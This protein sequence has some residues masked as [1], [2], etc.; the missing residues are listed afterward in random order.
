MR[1]FRN[2]ALSLFA[3]IFLSHFW[4]Y[5]SIAQNSI[6]LSVYTM[7]QGG[8]NRSLAALT[9][10]EFQFSSVPA[11]GL[12]GTYS[13]NAKDEGR[14]MLALGYQPYATRSVSNDPFSGRAID[15]FQMN[16]LFHYLVVAAGMRFNRVAGIPSVGFILRGGLSLS[17]TYQSTVDV[18]EVN[19]EVQASTGALKSFTIPRDRAEPSV[20]ALLEAVPGEWSFVEG[21]TLNLVVQ[22]GMVING[23]VRFIPPKTIPPN[24][25]I[26]GQD[27]LAGLRTFN[28][29]PISINIGLR[30]SWQRIAAL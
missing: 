21:Q 30:Y 28:I 13:L 12:E 19:G 9:K 5:Q 6:G 4:A 14:A 8:F 23:L 10:T 18:F 1:T 7:A 11:F 20:E 2:F 27:P 22:A 24:Y 16:T 29:Q 3:I 17:Q 15:D 26:V 25:N